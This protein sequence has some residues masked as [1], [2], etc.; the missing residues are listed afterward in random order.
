[1][2]YD[3]KASINGQT[4][5]RVAYGDMQAWLIINQLSHDGC[6]DI[7]M[8]ERGTSGGVEDGKI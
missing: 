7:C 4:V 8:S 5:L 1:M 6:K 2:T 3:I